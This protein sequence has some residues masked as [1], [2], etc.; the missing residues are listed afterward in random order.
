[1]IR[2]KCP[3]CGNEL[4]VIFYLALCPECHFTATLGVGGLTPK[5]HKALLLLASHAG[6]V[7]LVYATLKNIPGGSTQTIMN[8]ANFDKTEYQELLNFYNGLAHKCE[9]ILKGESPLTWKEVIGD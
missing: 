2:G 7:I 8:D 1:M 5:E 3:E 6:K 4:D 9:N